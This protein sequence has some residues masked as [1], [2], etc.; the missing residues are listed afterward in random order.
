M[1]RGCET[2]QT[3]PYDD[4][5]MTHHRVTTPLMLRLAASIT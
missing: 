5:I 3:R 1:G 4:R 2:V